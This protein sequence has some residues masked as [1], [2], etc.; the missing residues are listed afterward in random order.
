MW[1]S[2]GRSKV[3]EMTSPC[4]AR[5]K[6]VT[7]SGRS[8][9]STTIS[10]TSGLLVVMALAIACMIIVLPALDGETIRPRWPLPTGQIRS[11]IRPTSWFGV[12]SSLSRSCG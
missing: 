6:S 4:T 8:S 10:L 5:W 3:E 7:S 12:V 11:M 9:T 1:S 2:A